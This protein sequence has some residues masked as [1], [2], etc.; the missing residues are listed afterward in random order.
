MVC[1]FPSL[2]TTAYAFTST[3]LIVWVFFN[4]AM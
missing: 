1:G 4:I 3:A 2:H